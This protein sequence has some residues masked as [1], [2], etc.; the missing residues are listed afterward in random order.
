MMI[1]W[2]TI[3]NTKTIKNSPT[4]EATLEKCAKVVEKQREVIKEQKDVVEKQE[5]L[6]EEL[7][8]NNKRIKKERDDTVK[9]LTFTNILALL[10]ILL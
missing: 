3:G 4:C 8:K 2:T 7:E 9:S 6:V 10:L 5:E 1:S